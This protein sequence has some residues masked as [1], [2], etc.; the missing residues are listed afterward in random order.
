MPSA[1]RHPMK[2]TRRWVTKEFLRQI[3]LFDSFP[4]FEM[5]YLY[6]LTLLFIPIYNPLVR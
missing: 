5:S 4:T 3:D 2:S 6:K 1:R